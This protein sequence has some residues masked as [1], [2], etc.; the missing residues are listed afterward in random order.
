[1]STETGLEVNAEEI[2]YYVHVSSSKYGT[3]S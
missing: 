3:K 1:M 2:K